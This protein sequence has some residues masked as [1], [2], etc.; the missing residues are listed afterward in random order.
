MVKFEASNFTFSV[1]A[2]V[3][4]YVKFNINLILNLTLIIIL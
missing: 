4:L 1:Q 2:W 3:L